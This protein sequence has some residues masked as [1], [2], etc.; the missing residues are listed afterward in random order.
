MGENTKF[1][2]L[3]VWK[4]L[5]LFIVNFFLH[6]LGAIV[7]GVIGACPFFFTPGRVYI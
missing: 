4:K 1:T 6:Y 2:T 7:E 3:V 5:V